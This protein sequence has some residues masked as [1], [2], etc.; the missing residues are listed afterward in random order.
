MH[1]QEAHLA[2]LGERDDRLFGRDGADAGDERTVTRDH[3]DER[4]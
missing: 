3:R 4:L 2:E 1:D